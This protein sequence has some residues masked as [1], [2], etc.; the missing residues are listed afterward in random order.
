[1]FKVPIL[2]FIVPILVF[3][4]KHFL[5]EVRRKKLPA[6]YAKNAKRNGSEFA[7]SRK[8]NILRTGT[9]ELTR[10]TTKKVRKITTGVTKFAEAFKDQVRRQAAVRIAESRDGIYRNFYDTV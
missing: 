6:K 8:T 5:V 2:V 1:M 9:H 4:V 10:I 3:I 7:G